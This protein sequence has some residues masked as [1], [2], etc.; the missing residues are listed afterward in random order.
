MEQGYEK[1][2]K[3]RK[4]CNKGEGERERMI[5]QK[6][7]REKREGRLH[8]QGYIRHFCSGGFGALCILLL[9][10]TR[11]PTCLAHGAG[12]RQNSPRCP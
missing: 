8:K 1:K 7:L 11:L 5:E 3:L 10:K 9:R 2:G 6:R 4:G 12:P